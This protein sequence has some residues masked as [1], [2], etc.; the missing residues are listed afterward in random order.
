MRAAIDPGC[1]H[2]WEDWR[3]GPEAELTGLVTSN[4]RRVLEWEAE[5]EALLAL[6]N[7]EKRTVPQ[8]LAALEW[9]PDD[10]AQQLAASG[11]D[12]RLLHPENSTSIRDRLA[13]VAT[14]ISGLTEPPPLLLAP[15]EQAWGIE[16]A[17]RFLFIRASREGR[18]L[19]Q[20]I[21]M[22]AGI[23]ACGWADPSPERF[24]P[25]MSAWS[26][27]MRTEAWKSLF[28]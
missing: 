28:K 18:P 4:G 15:A 12:R 22:L 19:S 16:V 24:G 27:I 2:A 6:L 17:R 20:A 5:E 23:Y 13:H 25:A 26:R 21:M 7:P 8:I 11:L 14:Y 3:D 1:M 10:L 9:T